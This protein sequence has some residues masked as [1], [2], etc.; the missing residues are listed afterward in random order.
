MKTWP[1]CISSA[2][3]GLSKITWNYSHAGLV[4][5]CFLL[6]SCSLDVWNWRAW[7]WGCIP[8]LSAIITKSSMNSWRKEPCLRMNLWWRRNSNMMALLKWK[9]N[10]ISLHKFL[11]ILGYMRQFIPFINLKHICKLKNKKKLNTYICDEYYGLLSVTT[12][13]RLTSDQEK[14]RSK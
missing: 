9:M 2:S 5:S 13:F 1:Q 3:I 10:S 11:K 7:W 8:I 4:L 14:L 12:Y 6:A